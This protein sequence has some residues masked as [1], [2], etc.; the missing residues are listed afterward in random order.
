MKKPLFLL[1]IFARKLLGVF[2]VFIIVLSVHAQNFIRYH[3][4]PTIAFFIH[5]SFNTLLS[6]LQREGSVGAGNTSL[7]SMLSLPLNTSQSFKNSI[8]GSYFWTQRKVTNTEFPCISLPVFICVS[9]LCNYS[10]VIRA[11]KQHWNNAIES[12]TLVGFHGRFT[13]FGLLETKDYRLGGL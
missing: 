1:L 7:N 6:Y 13:S 4:L 3:N 10:I 8:V 11:E 9:I 5:P 12:K 2:I